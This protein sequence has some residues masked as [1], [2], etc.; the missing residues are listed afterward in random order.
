MGAGFEGPCEALYLGKKILVIPMTG[1]YEQQCNAAAL[2]SVGV[3]VIPLLSEI[4]IPRITAW[5]QQDQEIDIVFPEDTAQ[6]AVRRLY[7]LRMQES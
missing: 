5:L 6:K 3:P 4:Y 7:E 2:A 1:Q